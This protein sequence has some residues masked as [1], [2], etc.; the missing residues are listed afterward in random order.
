MK[1]LKKMTF[2]LDTLMQTLSNS[3]PRSILKVKVICR[4]SDNLILSLL[5]TEIDESITANDTFI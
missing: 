3:Y 1:I 4:S 5:F 2:N